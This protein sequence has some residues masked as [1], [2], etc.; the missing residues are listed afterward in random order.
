MISAIDEQSHHIIA[1]QTEQKSLEQQSSNLNK[2]E[3]LLRQKSI[4]YS[5]TLKTYQQQLA[6]YNP[7][8]LE[9]V[10]KEIQTL[11]STINGIENRLSQDKISE[12]IRNIKAS[13]YSLF[14]EF[15]EEASKLYR[16][17]NKQRTLYSVQSLINKLT[18]IGK[19]CKHH[20]DLSQQ[21]QQHQEQHRAQLE[22]QLSQSN[23]RIASFQ[24]DI[25]QQ[26][27]FECD[28]IQ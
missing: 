28:K 24:S 2:E 9:T 21:S 18:S 6:N 23:E 26:K 3:N 10:H 7:Q 4:E 11:Q 13:E 22:K 27:F 5:N 19:D 14:K 15:I 1:L 12:V 16:D 20:I 8:Q 25:K 17:N